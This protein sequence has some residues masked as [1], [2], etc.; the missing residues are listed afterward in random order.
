MILNESSVRL[1]TS[2][3]GLKMRLR[4]QFGGFGEV[5]SKATHC[6]EWGIIWLISQPEM[7]RA[8]SSPLPQRGRGVQCYCSTSEL[9]YI[10][11]RIIAEGC[12]PHTGQYKAVGQ[13]GEGTEKDLFFSILFCHCNF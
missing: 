2:I 1:V 8:V 9:S 10:S 5:G 11:S 7:H 3:A 13:D 4:V 6:C 12:L